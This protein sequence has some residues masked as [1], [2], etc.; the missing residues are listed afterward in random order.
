MI[1]TVLLKKPKNKPTRYSQTNAFPVIWPSKNSRCNPSQPQLLESQNCALSEGGRSWLQYPSRIS[2][3]LPLE[4]NKARLQPKEHQVTLSLDVTNMALPTA[5]KWCLPSDRE[6]MEA[7]SLAAS[8]QIRDCPCEQTS[9][10]Q[11]QFLLQEK[12]VATDLRA[13]KQTLLN[14]TPQEPICS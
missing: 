9:E 10:G 8:H 12:I 5:E 7:G 2:Q 6:N 11:V 4:E 13:L 14:K 1:V 3:M